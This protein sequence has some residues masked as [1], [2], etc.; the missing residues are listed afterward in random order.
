MSGCG[1]DD[2]GGT[3]QTGTPPLTGTSIKVLSGRADM[4]TGGDALVEVLPPA[5]AVPAT[6]RVS[7]G[8]RDQSANFAVRANGR[9]IGLVTGLTAGTN[10]IEA[11]SSN[12]SF[13]GARLTV[14]NAGVNA[15]VLLRSHIEPYI[16][17]TPQAV[18]ATADSAG[19][20]A[21]GLSAAP[22]DA[23][24]TTRA[25]TKLYY[26]T[27]T[28]AGTGGCA[29][30]IP[31]PSPT[32]ANP[33]PTTPANSCFQPY[34]AGTTQASA[35]ATTTP[36]GSTTAVP[37][38]VR[39]ERGVINRGIYDIA[40]LFDPSRP[41]TF[42]APQPQW[43]GKVVH[44]F[45]GSTGQPR[46]QARPNSSWVDNNALSRGYMVAVNS[47]TDSANNSN[48][49]LVAET[50]M[51]MK[52]HI[53]EQYGELRAYIGN[54][55]SGGAINQN[56]VASIS[57]GLLDG[58]QIQLDFADSVTTAIEVSDCVQLV[59]FYAGPAWTGLMQ[60][61]GLT[62]AQI[63]AKKAAINGHLDQLGCH[64]W[65][66][67]FGTANKPGNY[68]AVLVA[69]AAGQLFTSPAVTNN[70]RLPAAQVYDRVRN[71][72]GIR[73][74]DPDAAVAVWGTT[75]GTNRA[76]Q[77]NDN[78]GV[79]YGLKALQS[80]AITPEEFVTLNEGVGG[81]DA[82]SNLTPQRSVADLDALRTA[83]R[84]GLVVSG[85]QVSR[86]PIIDQRTPDEQGIHYNWRSFSQRDRL[87]RDNGGNFGN[88]V[89]WRHNGGASLA[90]LSLTTMDSWLNA[91]NTS[92]PKPSA[93]AV[94][95]QAQVI[96]GKPATAFD[97]CYLSTD[98]TYSNQ[99]RDFTTCDQDPPLAVRSS[100]RQ[101]AG[102][103]RTE[104]I[105][106]CQL[107]A[108]N[109]ADYG[110]IVFTETQ[111]ARLRAVFATG[112]CDWSR[113]G[114]NQEATA[115]PLTFAAGPGGVPLAPEPVSTP[116]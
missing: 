28:A 24:C 17:A 33:A 15:P 73:C 42:D 32:A 85:T 55:G 69:N 111:Q 74:S 47:L 91:L 23:Q 64:S 106:K 76:N 51:K 8:G 81:S 36:L 11:T 94:R 44:N 27:L 66:N 61:Q 39:V 16:C 113:P 34:V 88:Q 30:V 10:T 7:V 109:F 5:G 22:T 35:I 107:K 53:I 26:R 49:V 65:N 20:N 2:D 68:Q 4:V 38:I 1:D 50:V 52:E 93:N 71:P 99:V 57:P 63:N 110:T 96:A 3:G 92:A 40:V 105:L 9:V 67:A 31:D 86:V 95:T 100:P 77:T 108:L 70:C 79:Q 48:R 90:G 89:I 12:G 13:A 58:L 41:W 37:Y 114:V 78:V 25:E 19:T 56:T 72:N 29:F 80:G 116:I 101:V 75:P 21:S 82:D 97:F 60:Q 18:A 83:Y 59:N 87:A 62:Q 104:D 45:G 102:G 84:A 54:G 103:P 98:A 115:S 112:V 46:L 6:L 43:T 14:T